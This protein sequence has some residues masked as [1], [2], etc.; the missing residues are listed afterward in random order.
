[1]KLFCHKLQQ[2]LRKQLDLLFYDINYA[3]KKFYKS[4][5]DCKS[6]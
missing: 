5:C 2:N 3:N 1:M 4:S 6:S